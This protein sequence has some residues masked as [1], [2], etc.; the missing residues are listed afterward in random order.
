MN[1]DQLARR[2]P[3]LTRRGMI[4]LRQDDPADSC[5]QQPHKGSPAEIAAQRRRREREQDEHN[6]VMR[7][8]SNL[9]R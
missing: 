5:V 1:A 3:E 8:F 6:E 2:W 4:S 7:M 9:Q